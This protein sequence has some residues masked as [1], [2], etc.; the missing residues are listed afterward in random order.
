VDRVGA[1]ESSDTT[2]SPQEIAIFDI[3]LQSNGPD[4]VLAV[5]FLY[6]TLLC[7]LFILPHHIVMFEILGDSQIDRD[8]GVLVRIQRRVDPAWDVY[9]GREIGELRALCSLIVDPTVVQPPDFVV[10][11]GL[12]SYSGGAFM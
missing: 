8:F 12:Y 4:K 10:P 1:N 2:D 9:S 7:Q 3:H 11:V 5:K 6:D